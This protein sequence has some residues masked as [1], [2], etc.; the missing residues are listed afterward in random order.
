VSAAQVKEIPARL[1]KLQAEVAAM[2]K[3]KGISR[4]AA[5]AIAK[6]VDAA[7]AAAAGAQ[8]PR[9]QQDPYYRGVS[10]AMGN[11]RKALQTANASSPPL[12]PGRPA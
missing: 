1:D 9:R 5:A 8:L 3:E 6:A 4:E 7:R 10:G 11:V 2:E 12:I